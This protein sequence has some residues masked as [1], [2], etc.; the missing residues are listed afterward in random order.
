MRRLAAGL[1]MRTVG[2]LMSVPHSWVEKIEQ[3]ERR[4]DLMEYAILCRTLK[5]DPQEGFHIL[6]PDDAEHNNNQEL[7]PLKSKQS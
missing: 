3:G 5:C 1:S 7:R 2:R 6:I 4:L